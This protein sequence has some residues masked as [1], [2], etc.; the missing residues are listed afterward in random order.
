[1]LIIVHF[2][3][4]DSWPAMCYTG[5]I[6]ILLYMHSENISILEKS[7]KSIFMLKMPNVTSVQ[8]HLY[9]GIPY[10]HCH[11]SIVSVKHCLT[12]EQLKWG[13]ILPLILFV[14]QVCLIR[15]L[16]SLSRDYTL[17]LVYG[18]WFT[19]L[20][21]F[22]AI[23]VVVYRYTCFYLLTYVILYITGLLLFGF[24]L[25]A[26]VYDSQR[27]DSLRQQYYD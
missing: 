9:C 1:M 20:L 16:L 25:F 14:L 19:C 22:I 21:I 7:Q 26:F 15:E 12:D 5:L 23:L 2:D 3:S 10:D 13:R 4:N 24:V 17:S 6:V 11:C 18:T 8:F 27:R